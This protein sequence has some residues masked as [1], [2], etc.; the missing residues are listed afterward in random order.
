MANEK[1]TI[2]LTGRRPVTIA[3]AD[4]PVLASATERPGDF[5]NGTPRP[6]YE[7][8]CH[9]ITVRQHVDGR[10][11]VYAVLDAAT[12]WTGTQGYR[13]GEL[14]PTYADPQLI[15]DAIRRVGAECGILDSVVRDCVAD[16]PAEELI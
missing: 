4:W 3:K 14:L 13:G 12:V 9:R 7:T 2:T 15:A 10:C 16:L 5:V 6:D 8:D 11:V 1:L